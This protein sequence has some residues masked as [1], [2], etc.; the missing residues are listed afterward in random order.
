MRSGV[1]LGVER[2]AVNGTVEPTVLVVHLQVQA[3]GPLLHRPTVANECSVV[4]QGVQ[5]SKIEPW[6]SVLNH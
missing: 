4:K 1:D 6:P 5:S 2:G 3:R